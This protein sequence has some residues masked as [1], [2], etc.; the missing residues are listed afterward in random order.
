MTPAELSVMTELA[1]VR[2]LLSDAGQEDLLGLHGAQDRGKILEQ[3]GV[4]A[5]TLESE[6]GE[7]LREVYVH[8]GELFALLSDVDGSRPRQTIAE[9]LEHIAELLMDRRY[10]SHPSFLTEPKKADLELLLRWMVDA[11]QEAVSVSYDE[12]TGKALKMLAQPL[13]LVNLGQTK[14]S[15]RLDGRIL[16]DLLTRVDQPSVGWTPIADHL[17]DAYGLQPVLIDLFLCFLCQRDHRAIGELD[18]SPIG[19][20]SSRTATSASHR[21]RRRRPTATPS[22]SA[23]SRPGPTP[24]WAQHATW[25][26][27]WKCSATRSRS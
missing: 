21:S 8:H 25:F 17:R 23:S 19:W 10:P 13:E 11:G 15:L 1:A 5:S 26:R 7:L 14:A 22:W 9:N 18:A 16:K 2:Y 12:A 20:R 24:A 4:R 27:P 3:A 6:L